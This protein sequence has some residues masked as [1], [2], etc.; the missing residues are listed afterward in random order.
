MTDNDRTGQNRGYRP[1]SARRENVIGHRSDGYRRGGSPNRPQIQIPR[2]SEINILDILQHGGVDKA[3]HSWQP[4]CQAIEIPAFNLYEIQLNKKKVMERKLQEKILYTGGEDSPL[5]RVNKRLKYTDLTPTSI[6]SLEFVV[7]QYVANNE[8]RFVRFINSTGPITLK[9]HSLE[10]LP[11]V[12]KKLMWD[13][14]N[15]RE[16][17]PFTNYEDIH[18]RVPTFRP[19]DVIMKRIIEELKDN[20][21]VS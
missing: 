20:R 18:K 5:G 21:T 19:V 16:H 15:Q 2:G 10:V 3:G 7:G 1:Q 12:G 9:R 14:I 11:G 8:E 6:T 17:Q 13:L 4:I